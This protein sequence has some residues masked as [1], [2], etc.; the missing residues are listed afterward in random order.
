M[1]NPI[2]QLLAESLRLSVQAPDDDH[3]SQNAKDR[4]ANE[5][6]QAVNCADFN[7]VHSDH[8]P[9]CVGELRAQP[10]RTRSQSV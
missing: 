3:G 10:G 1:A 4:P 7:P 5:G 8:A 2:S 9:M 6:K